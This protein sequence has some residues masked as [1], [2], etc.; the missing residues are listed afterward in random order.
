LTSL[1]TLIAP[2]IQIEERVA[3]PKTLIAPKTQIEGRVATPK[4]LFSKLFSTPLQLE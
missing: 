3:T 2:K 4:T 1:Q